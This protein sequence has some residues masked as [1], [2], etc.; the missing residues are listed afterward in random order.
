MA[1]L[2]RSTAGSVSLRVVGVD[3]A[4][5]GCLAGPVIA[6]A[7]VFDGTPR[8]EGLADSK[9]LT[10]ARRAS[11]AVHI[12]EQALTW[13]IARAEASEID[14]INILRA[15]LLAMKRAVDALSIQP[16]WVRVDGNHYPDIPC[17]GEAVVKGDASVAEI[18]AASILAKVARDRE[19]ALLDRICPGYAFAAHKGYPTQQH[20]ACLEAL[21]VTQWHRRTYAPVRRLLAGGGR[22]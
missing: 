15:S 17:P 13:A 12:K 8:I 9:T 19:M 20:L 22:V 1:V 21:G 7:V 6:A 3:E 10:A 4:G 16:D 11:I 14:C 5:R 2:P 18:A